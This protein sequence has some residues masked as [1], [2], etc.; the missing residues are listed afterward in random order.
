MNT[1]N[2][3]QSAGDIFMNGPSREDTMMT[4]SS[5]VC[6]DNENYSLVLSVTVLCILFCIDM[7]VQNLRIFYSTYLTT[8]TFLLLSII[9]YHLLKICK[10]ISTFMF[11]KHKIHYDSSN[12]P[13]KRPTMIADWLTESQSLLYDKLT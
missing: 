9:K 4:S 7:D 13:T 8:N 6:V 12:K 3:R 1:S 10:L 5:R 2:K 11:F